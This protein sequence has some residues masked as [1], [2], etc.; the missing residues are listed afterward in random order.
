MEYVEGE[1][2]SHR[3]HRG[4]FPVREAVDIAVQIDDALVEAHARGIVHRDIK[5]ANIIV[6]GRG[7]VKVLDFGLAKFL[8]PPSGQASLDVALTVGEDTLAGAVLG[9]VS[10]M[11]PEQ[12]LGRNVDQR[13]DLFSA[14]VV[15]YEML[16]GRLPFEGRTFGEVVDAILHHI[17]TPLARL[18]PAVAGEPGVARPQGARE[19]RGP[20]LPD[21]AGHVQRPAARE[22]RARRDRASRRTSCAARRT[23]GRRRCRPP[24]T[25]LPSSRSPTSRA[26]RPTSGSGRA[27]PRR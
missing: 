24:T 10:Y 19:E 27:L 13:S 21:R 11:A 9:T 25:R 4:P 8:E 22:D 2:L 26:S 17:P 20:A 15:I 6:T 7:Q 14:G 1:L 5:S 16:T 23:T 18:N 12:A 3:I